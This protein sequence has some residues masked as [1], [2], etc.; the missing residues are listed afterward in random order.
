MGI[1]QWNDLSDR[2]RL[3]QF[4]SAV[5]TF[6]MPFTF[7]HAADLHLDSPFRGIRD[8]APEVAARL[9]SATF[10]AYAALINLC[11]D[12][13]ANF[14]LIAGDVYDG[15]DRSLAAQL[16]FRDG[17]VRLS[18][19]GIPAFIVHGNHD[20]LEGWSSA[21][22]WPEQTTIFGGDDVQTVIVEAGGNPI[23]AVSGISYPTQRENRNLAALFR[24]ERPDLFQIAL[25]HCNCGG[26]ADHESYAPC[27]PDDL[28]R[29]DFDYWALGHVHTMALLNRNPH[30]VY[31]GTIQGRSI[32]ETGP[33]GC[34]LM[35]VG[36]DRDV[37]EEF[38]PL[39]A[40][41]WFA[42]E[43]RIEELDTVDQLEGALAD[44]VDRVREGA[45]GRPAVCRLTMVGRGPLYGELN[46]EGTL[47]G[48]LERLR[49]Q[50][51]EDE[52]FVWVERLKLRGAPA[53]DLEQRCLEKDLLGELLRITNDLRGDEDLVERLSL[54]LVEL[55]EHARARRA[56]AELTPD[57]F[58]ALLDDAANLCV[59]LL[60]TGP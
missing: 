4:C 7:V 40:V 34:Y 20:P 60:E 17:L 1:P 59:D 57:D 55:H 33:R 43:V 31:P 6:T 44:D 8:E 27:S 26:Q 49:E 18:E 45:E 52:P 12:R 24:A 19:A 56:L 14:L 29:A 50:G 53:I 38:C 58:H 30:I 51:L 22:T 41:R 16:R 35:T 25:L 23:A 46:R 11:I 54:A 9:R 13:D 48:L 5:Y 47:Q 32:R 42:R 37:K 3:V 28:I 21:L 36:D 2:R 15:A 39:D 10:D